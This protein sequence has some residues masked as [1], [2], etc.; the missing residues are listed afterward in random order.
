MALLAEE[1]E[2][3]PDTPLKDLVDEVN[4]EA[5]K[6]RSDFAQMKCYY[7]TGDDRGKSLKDL[8]GGG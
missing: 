4:K 2:R 7:K 3:N 6:R 8:M 1:I 5:K